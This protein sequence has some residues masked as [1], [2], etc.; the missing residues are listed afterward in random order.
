[1]YEGSMY[2]TVAGLPL[3]LKC[4]TIWSL[5]H[6]PSSGSLRLPPASTMAEVPNTS[7]PAPSATTTTADPF[8]SST[9][10]RCCRQPRSPSV[11]TGTSGTR[12]KSTS[13]EQSVACTAIMPDERPISLTI[14]IPL[15]KLHRASV[16]ADSIAACASSTAVLKPKARSIRSISL[17]IVL[18]MP[19][20]AMFN[21]KRRA[22]SAILFAARCVP[23]P[24]TTYSCEM[25]FCLRK[26]IVLSKSNE[27]RP[28]PIMVPPLCCRPTTFASVNST[29]GKFG[30]EKPW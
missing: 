21:F 11:T 17:S 23:S 22:S 4:A 7:S 2:L 15:G 14:P 28:V 13:P 10:S 24:P 12:H 29:G 18:G 1:M 6:S 30:S 27:P 5:S 16:C 3:D 25:R 26:P 19:H 9:R 8:C 20:T